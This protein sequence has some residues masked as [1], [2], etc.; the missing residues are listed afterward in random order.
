MK[1]LL[2]NIQFEIHNWNICGDSKV[3]ALLLAL[4]HAYNKFC[5]FLCELLLTVNIITSNKSGLNEKKCVG[6]T[7]LTNTEKVYLY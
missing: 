6:T 4:Q 3:T 1:L 5:W 2:E 7:Q